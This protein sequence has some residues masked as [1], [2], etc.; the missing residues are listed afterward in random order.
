MP[1]LEILRQTCQQ[2]RKS[3]ALFNVAIFIGVCVL[4][5]SS[6]V[7]YF[8]LMLLPSEIAKYNSYAMA[9]CLFFMILAAIM[10]S[11]YKKDM[12]L[13][14]SEFKS[15]KEYANTN[16]CSEAIYYFINHFIHKGESH[17]LFN[18][19]T[20]FNL[21]IKDIDAQDI[22]GMTLLHHVIIHDSYSAFIPQLLLLNAD[23]DIADKKGNTAR[24]LLKK[25]PSQYLIYIEQKKLSSLCEV[26]QNHSLPVK[27]I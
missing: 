13:F 16:Q 1:F 12:A 2:L 7:F 9:S 27:R 24:M 19:H 15:I 25:S 21:V 26:Q 18:S 10:N 8:F 6:F 4:S 5:L 20:F 3:P 23:I 14:F 11:E 17:T 22:N